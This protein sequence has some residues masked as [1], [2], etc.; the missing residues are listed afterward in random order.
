MLHECWPTL[1]RSV[2]FKWTSHGYKSAVF[3]LQT[4][5]LSLF[6]HCRL[7]PAWECCYTCIGIII[8]IIVRHFHCSQ[9]LVRDASLQTSLVVVKCCFY[10]PSQRQQSCME[11]IQYVQNFIL[12]DWSFFFLFVTKF[13]F[14]FSNGSCD[15]CVGIWQRIHWTA[16][17]CVATVLPPILML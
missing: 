10:L 3:V 17:L 2:S 15:K 16:G 9:V 12:M 4:T 11:K 14:K 5:K 13:S 1:S 7:V 8:I 6:T